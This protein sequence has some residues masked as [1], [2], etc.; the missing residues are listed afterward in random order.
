MA[1]ILICEDDAAIRQLLCDL[2]DE[3][4][5]TPIPTSTGADC[6]MQGT[7]QRPSIIFVDIGLPGA[8]NGFDVCRSLRQN[9]G[10]KESYIVIVTGRHGE[11]AIQS[12]KEAG[13]NAFLRKPF[14]Q[15]ELHEVIARGLKAMT[16]E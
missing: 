16:K 5:H 10:T 3:L 12:A 15:S 13:A 8:I 14:K 1:T 6:I 9:A 7:S 11:A 2:C 4:G